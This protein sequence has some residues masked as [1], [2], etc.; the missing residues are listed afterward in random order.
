MG[1][2]W[3]YPEAKGNSKQKTVLV[4]VA[5]SRIRRETFIEGLRGIG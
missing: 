2:G 1:K 3:N 4:L 5:G